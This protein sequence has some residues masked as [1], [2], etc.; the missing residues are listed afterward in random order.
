MPSNYRGDNW[1]DYC[2]LTIRFNSHFFLL[3]FYSDYW[4][5]NGEKMCVC[6]CVCVCVCG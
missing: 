5:D 6:V 1:E 4:D 3:L 2:I